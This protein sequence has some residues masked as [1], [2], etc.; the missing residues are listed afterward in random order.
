M[1]PNECPTYEDSEVYTE[2]GKYDDMS[3]IELLDVMLGV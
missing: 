3:H 1:T 2:E